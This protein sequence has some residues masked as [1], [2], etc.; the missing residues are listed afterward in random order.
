MK[1][2]KSRNLYQEPLLLYR[3]SQESDTLNKRED[4]SFYI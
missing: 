2:N 3:N 1:E 4:Q